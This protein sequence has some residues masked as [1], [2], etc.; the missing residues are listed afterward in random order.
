MI[1][2]SPRQIGSIS[3]LMPTFNGDAFLERVMAALAAQRLDLPWTFLAVDSGS[4]DSTLQI[5]ESWRTRFPVELRVH[6]VHPSTFDHGDTRNLLAAESRGELLVFLTQDA[7]PRDADWLSRLVANFDD[8]TVGAAY[9]RN[10]PRPDADLLTRAFSAHDPGYA[11][12]RRLWDGL[13]PDGLCSRRNRAIHLRGFDRH[14][15]ERPDAQPDH[16]PHFGDAIRGGHLSLYDYRDRCEQLSRQPVVLYRDCGSAGLPGYHSQPGNAAT[17]C[18]RD[19]LQPNDLGCRWNRALRLHGY[20]RG[21][22]EWT[23]A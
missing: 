4:T 23:D 9:C 14:T 18:H 3:V 13:Q 20:K 11:A 2:V 7:I 6:H 12:E 19:A 5:L 1:P 17:R 8:S 10:V 22:T 15:A 16:R 21:T